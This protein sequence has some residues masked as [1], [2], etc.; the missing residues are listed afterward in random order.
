MNVLW[1][2]RFIVLSFVVRLCA[3]ICLSGCTNTQGADCKEMG[4]A[5]VHVLHAWD[6]ISS[7]CTWHACPSVSTIACGCRS[8]LTHLRYAHAADVVDGS[9]VL[10]VKPYLPFCESVSGAV[11]PEWVQ[12]GCRSH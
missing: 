7:V 11:A 8:L 1:F 2:V 10:D 3:P 6:Y 9:P 5:T 4:M 12:V